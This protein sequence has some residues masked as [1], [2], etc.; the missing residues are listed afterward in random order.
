MSLT[1]HIVPQLPPAVSGVGDYALLVGSAMQDLSTG[2]C[3]RYIACGCVRTEHAPD[4]TRRNA[5][6]ACEPSRLWQEVREVADELGYAGDGSALIV[7]YS[8]YGYDRNGAPGWL[9]AALERRPRDLKGVRVVTMFHELYA[10]SWPWR[11]AFWYS[12]R[13]RLVAARIARA[14]D[15][16]VTN[17]EA[18]AR[19][20]ERSGHLAPGS[21]ASLPVASNVGEPKEIVPWMLRSR[22]AVMFGATRFK[23][24][25]LVGRG[26]RDAASL[27]RNLEIET[28]VSIGTPSEFDERAFKSNG[29]EVVQTG[30]VAAADVSSHYRAARFALVDYFPGYYSKSGVL[31]AAASHGTPPIF[32]WEGRASDGLKF[33]EHLWDLP[34]ALR[35]GAEGALTRL[36]SISQSIRAWYEWHSVERHARLLLDATCPKPMVAG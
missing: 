10:M 1:I 9:A 6:G 7:H 33:G 13:Q 20:L 12:L 30:V 17:R 24:P 34:A 32:P 14:S 31:A 25:F 23:R 27:C 35:A 15:V 2:E 11:R 19:W 18:S 26:A 5:T 21:V 3:C 36:V 22:V 8:G 16:I 4:G 28:L 29:I